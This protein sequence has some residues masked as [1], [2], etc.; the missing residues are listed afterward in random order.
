MDYEAIDS[1]V[2]ECMPILELVDQ[3]ELMWHYGVRNL[4]KAKQEDDQKRY[5]P[6]LAAM[7]APLC[8]VSA[9]Q[10]HIAFSEKHGYSVSRVS[11]NE[12]YD[13][14]ILKGTT[15]DGGAC[16]FFQQ[17]S[18]GVDDQYR[19]S[20][21]NDIVVFV[22]GQETARYSILDY[23]KELFEKDRSTA[24]LVIDAL[25]WLRSRMPRK[26]PKLYK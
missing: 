4:K 9:I 20:V 10:E 3:N 5:N 25:S 22:D 16:E 6:C 23:R 13:N 19:S 24:D 12:R 21:V 26:K 7:Q 2:E 17:R 1:L 18:S 15:K 8:L 11:L 14:M